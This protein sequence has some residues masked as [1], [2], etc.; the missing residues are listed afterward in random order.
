[1]RDTVTVTG[2]ILTASPVREYDKR[3]EL[4][5]K[6][7]G[8][9]SAF[10]QGA[11]KPNSVLSASTIPFTFGTFR[12]YPGRNAY[13]LKSAEIKNYFLE[14]TEDFD[15]L[16]YASYFG[17]L[18]RY[19]TRENVEASQELT[20]LYIS[21]R[22]LT[23]GLVSRPLIRVIYE[24][25]LMQIEGEA[26]E[27]FQCVKCGKEQKHIMVYFS[28]GGIV[29]RDCAKHHPN[30]AEG[31]GWS[32]SSQAIYTLQVILTRS[33]EK[34]YSFRVTEK[35]EKELSAFMEE[36]FQYYLKADFKS[37]KFLT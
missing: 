32:L 20:L 30:L 23:R 35:I 9:I 5:T 18:A 3:I 36:Y 27:L 28:Q 15:V 4:L 25:R 7:Y 17:E 26:L 31:S 34:L 33:V 21:L 6:E 19:F 1:M 13:Q 16:C 24:M 12:L 29:C 22:A 37:L 10:A 11:R 8:R 2:M 14:I